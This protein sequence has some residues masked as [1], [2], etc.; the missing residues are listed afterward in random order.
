MGGE[1]MAP[2]GGGLFGGGLS[3]WAANPIRRMFQDL[4]RMFDGMQRA[5]SG[6]GLEAA[7]DSWVPALDV[8]DAEGEIIVDAEIPGVDP[9]DVQIEC[10][11]DLLV[12]QGQT[13][14]RQE[15]ERRFSRRSG[16]F[17][18]QL[19]IPPGVD[20]DKAR[21]SHKHGIVSIHF[22]KVRGQQENVKQIPITTESPREKAA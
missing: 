18:A 6:G 11:D 10:H 1:L 8:R 21:A 20:V 4:D 17:F 12:I 15:G 2:F 7:G 5:V 14:Q 3:P 9:K 16:S 19:P 13:E 22:P